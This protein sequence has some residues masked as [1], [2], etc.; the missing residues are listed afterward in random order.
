VHSSGVVSEFL[1]KRGIPVLSH[2]PYSPYLAL[3]DFFL[4]PELK[5]AMKGTR[6]EAV[7]S[8]QQIVMREVKA[9]REE[10]FSRTFDSLYEGCKCGAEVGRDYIE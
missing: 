1:V 10:L 4:F 3:A 6:F 7:S 5:I 2:P 9:I 8:I